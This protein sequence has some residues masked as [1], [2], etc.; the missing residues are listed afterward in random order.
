MQAGLK[1][2]NNAAEARR[3][4]THAAE[5]YL[6]SAGTFPQDDEKHACEFWCSSC[7]VSCYKTEIGQ[8]FLL[9]PLRPTGG[10]ELLFE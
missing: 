5:H 6:E 7:H 9:L 8:I 10:A 1:H 3:H 2:G 4:L